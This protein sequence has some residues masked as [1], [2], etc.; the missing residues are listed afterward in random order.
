MPDYD[1]FADHAFDVIKSNPDAVVILTGR[2]G[3]GKTTRL[4][5]ALLNTAKEEG[6]HP[7]GSIFSLSY[8]GKEE[9][10]LDAHE[11]HIREPGF[12]TIDPRFQK[13]YWYG[14]EGPSDLE[15]ILRNRFETAKGNGFFV[16]DE[17]VSAMLGTAN[18]I[19]TVLREAK[20]NEVTLAVTQ[21]TVP[22]MDAGEIE[23]DQRDMERL[24]VMSGKILKVVPISVQLVPQAEVVKVLEALG[25]D[26]ALAEKF[27]ANPL[28]RTL[29]M[30]EHIFNET[31]AVRNSDNSILGG[32]HIVK[33]S[34]AHILI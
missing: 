9:T 8:Y 2:R 4:I 5:P 10:H 14:E 17:A 31:V 22:D 21:P 6:F 15:T 25:I 16:I 30:V 20:T 26:V 33:K 28:M 1:Q 27:R 24:G 12:N 34:E 11:Y 32:D 18:V 13:P 23:Q 19:Q 3:I 29:R 7:L